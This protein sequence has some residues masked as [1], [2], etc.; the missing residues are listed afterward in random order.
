MRF[1]LGPVPNDPEF[2]T[3]DGGWIRLKEL[4]FS[5]MLLMVIP[6]SVLLVAGLS[7]AW[8]VVLRLQ[9]ASSAAEG[10]VTPAVAAFLVLGCGAIIVAHES[11][12]LLALPRLGL[13]D[14]TVLG[15][16]PQTFTPYVSY[17]GETSRARQLLVGLAPFLVLS[18]APLLAGIVL[19]PTPFWVVVVSLLNG[20]GASA[21]L[22]G[23]A[24]V[25]W[26][27]PAQGRVRSKGL[28]TWW[29]VPTTGEYSDSGIR[30]V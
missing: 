11:V 23:A 29:R 8:A 14:D 24:L 22:V 9:G 30:D 5:L 21:D 27:V 15:F 28:A 16:W 2:D 19:G 4:R 10:A 26:Q 12:H 20:L 13:T 25:A 6:V 18:I 3:A 1:R 17:E 7:S